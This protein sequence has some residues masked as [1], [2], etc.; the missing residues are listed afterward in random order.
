[1]SNILQISPTPVDQSQQIQSGQHRLQNDNPAIQNP[2]DPDAVNRADGQNAG[3]SGTATGEGGGRILD[4]EGNYASFLRNLRGLED[5]PKELSA[6]FFSDSGMLLFQ[7]QE[8][9]GTALSGL[10]SSMELQNPEELLAFMKEQGGELKFSGA[11]FD[12]LRGLMQERISEPLRNAILDFVKSY[13]DL[14]AGP[15]LLRQM[16]TI[17]GDIRNL[18]LSSAAEK[19]A[20]LTERLDLSA[21]PGDTEANTRLINNEILPFLSRYVSQTHDYGPVRN[22]AMLFIL[23]A[24]KY[25]NGDKETLEKLGQRLMKNSDFQLL[26]RGDPAALWQET[27][28]RLLKREAEDS[29]SSLFP[30]LLLA[31]AEGKAGS[32]N[33]MRFQEVLNGL[34][35]NESVYMPL[36]HSIFPF[37][38][39]GRQVMSEMWVEPEDRRR[40]GN[41][42]TKLLLRFHIQSVGD[43]ELVSLIRDRRVDL[44]LFLPEELMERQKEVEGKVSGILRK[45]GLSVA[46]LGIRRRMR[47]LRLAEVFPGLSEQSHGINIRI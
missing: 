29:F 18:M 8:G 11:F 24:V 22:A 16:R 41:G 37:R 45:N 26:F 10:F 20:A 9:L 4:F 13:N 32:E 12:G 30:K 33:S 40:G 31:G 28:E 35:V 1:M 5:F 27:A 34:L 17:A 21:L 6:L 15:H 14:S 42:G 19:F 36:R 3:G 44:Q 47:A 38:F 7:N 25:E 43:F 23:Y 2:A 39:R 46:N